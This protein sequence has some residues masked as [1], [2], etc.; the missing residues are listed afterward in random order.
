MKKLFLFITMLFLNVTSYAYD[1][2]VKN[3]DGKTIYYNYTNNGQEL[4]VTDG[5]APYSGVVNI[6]E[7]VTFMN[8][9][10]R[11]TS[12]RFSTSYSRDITSISIPCSITYIGEGAFYNCI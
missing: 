11:V 2:A 8:K 12:I 1:I 6:P 4:E 3:A 7:T 10:R 5:N 9:T